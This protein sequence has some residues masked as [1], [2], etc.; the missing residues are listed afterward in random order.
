M[1]CAA[2]RRTA[3]GGAPLATP[4]LGAGMDHVVALGFTTY[5]LLP[6]PP[7]PPL[8]ALPEPLPPPVFLLS[9]AS[10]RSLPTLHMSAKDCA[11]RWV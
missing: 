3:D 8:L 10:K 11:Q 5:L 1:L 9:R 4:P 7:P 2:A 6:P